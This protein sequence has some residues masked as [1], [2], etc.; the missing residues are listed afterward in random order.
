MSRPWG[1]DLREYKDVSRPERPARYTSS[2]TNSSLRRWKTSKYN[3]SNEEI[4][5]EKS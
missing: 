2:E 1:G 5:P 4:L 3:T